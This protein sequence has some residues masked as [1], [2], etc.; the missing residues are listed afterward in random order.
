MAILV[1]EIIDVIIM[2]VAVGYIFMDFFPDH[3]VKIS[4]GFDWKKL[5]IAVLITAPGIIFHELAHKFVALAFGMNATFH[6]AYFW[7][8]IGIA[9]KLMKF[10]FIF[11]V[12][13]YV[14]PCSYPIGSTALAACIMVLQNFPLRQAA[15]AF[16]GPFLN[17]VLFLGA[18]IALKKIK[19]PSKQVHTILYLTKQIN[20]FLFIFNMLPLPIFDGFK[21]YEGVFRAFF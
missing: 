6:A 2:S 19:N 15:I 8:A 7:L 10:K 17:L 21:V 13:G 11:F 20:L 14:Q 5:W 16:G 1:Q 12:P 9:L 3:D 18:M 4:F